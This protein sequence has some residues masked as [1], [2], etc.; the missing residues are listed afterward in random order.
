MSSWFPRIAC[1]VLLWAAH[2]AA[3][4]G[5]EMVLRLE[6]VTAHK[7][8]A[9][10][11]G[12][13]VLY[14]DMEGGAARQAYVM[15]P[16]RSGSN[17]PGTSSVFPADAAGLR[18]QGARLTGTLTATVV[19][20]GLSPEALVL[21]LDAEVAGGAVS[22]SYTGTYAG[23]AVG[24]GLRGVSMPESPVY[25]EAKVALMLSDGRASQTHGNFGFGPESLAVYLE[26]SNGAQTGGQANRGLVETTAKTEES[27][28]AHIHPFIGPRGELRYMATN[29][30]EIDSFTSRSGSLG[31]DTFTSSFDVTFL[32]LKGRK[33]TYQ[34]SGSVI[35]R[36]VLGTYSVTENGTPVL[37]ASTFVGNLGTGE[38]P[39]SD[40]VAPLL[41]L[42]LSDDSDLAGFR[43]PYFGALTPGEI[44]S[45]V[46]AGALWHAY[47]PEVGVFAD[48]LLVANASSEGN[49]HYDNAPFP[50]YGGAVTW[51]IISQLTTDPE[52]RDYARASAQRA[53]AW[54]D[55][56]GNNFGGLAEYY[57]QMFFFS[58]WAALAHLDL[59]E[60]TGEDRWLVAV[61]G[62]LDFLR[63]LIRTKMT[64]A[65]VRDPL[66]DDGVGPGRTWLMFD[67]ETGV[68]GEANLRYDRT[69]DHYE[70]H[71]MEY[72]WLLGRLRVAHGVTAYT[73]FE[74]QAYS[75]VLDNLNDESIWQYRPTGWPAPAQAIGPTLFALY[76]LDY[77]PGH[78][79]EVL[80][81]VIAHLESVYISWEHPRDTYG[82][83]D[84]YF[85][86][87]KDYYH[88][89][90]SGYLPQFVGGTAATSRMA[91]VY[92]KRYASLR[93][94]QDL[95]KAQAMALS[96]LNRQ[97]LSN[98]M[99]DN[100]GWR[101]FSDDHQVRMYDGPNGEPITSIERRGRR[102]T[103]TY[104]GLKANALRNLLDYAALLE[105]LGLG[106]TN[107]Q[108]I[109]APDVI[110]KNPSD[111]PFSLTATATSGLPVTYEVESGPIALNGAEVTLLGTPGI[112]RVIARQAGGEGWCEAAARTISISVGDNLPASPPTLTATTLNISTIRLEWTDAANNEAVYRVQFRPLGQED[113]AEKVHL[114]N[115]T[116]VE[117]GELTMGVTYEFQVVA[118]NAV[119][120]SAPSP[121]VTASPLAAPTYVYLE[122]GCSGVPQGMRSQT[123]PSAYGGEELFVT[124]DFNNRDLITPEA[125]LDLFFRAPVTGNYNLWLRGYTTQGGSSDSIWLKVD[126]GVH[127]GTGTNTFYTQAI[128][129]IGSYG[130]AKNGSV[131]PLTAGTTHKVT[132]AGRED[133]AVIDRILL[134]TDDAILT[135]FGMGDAPVNCGGGEP[136]DPTPRIALVIVAGVMHMEFA[137]T[138]GYSYQPQFTE[139]LS[140]DWEPMGGLVPGEGQM[141]RLPL[142]DPP[143]KIFFRVGFFPSQ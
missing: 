8:M 143:A 32:D 29:E 133:G 97:K 120:R 3:V 84:A 7:S 64:Y 114:A 76:L 92:L 37:P 72:L 90:V 66:P 22:G 17:Y 27:H 12:P 36:V 108:L 26:F 6:S 122:I 43:P 86:S 51:G 42:D 47:T 121:K 57:K 95:A 116:T 45:R 136:A 104:S 82:L 128:H 5:Q 44:R 71:P 70:L 127:V 49:K 4:S 53:G 102:D 10:V 52:L 115:T 101:E 81:Q 19:P 105:S 83:R 134:T 79:P 38:R 35:G 94:P 107:T 28:G 9:A 100:Q 118:E 14:L 75:W 89:W 130:W 33:F 23:L 85:P 135:N 96:T 139:D 132:I 50:A 54:I 110:Q 62:Y 59:Y 31:E 21:T 140:D 126:D 113:W 56:R 2:A 125:T 15:V 60:T 77:R 78:N 73:E 80:T 129:N 40:T 99:I 48:D 69:W 30:E 119:G 41:P 20:K 93:N 68:A 34:L 58:A 13:A 25:P 106:C 109:T 112:A 141:V 67:E 1:A 39:A 18:L 131:F 16:L 142:S 24:S 138:E 61:R 74:D 55:N 91:L 117:L 88:R 111:A 123:N 46:L 137:A 87:V 124:T 103:H 63:N 65:Q 98:G 11:R